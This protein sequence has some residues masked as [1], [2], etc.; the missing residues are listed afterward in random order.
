MNINIVYR[1]EPHEAKRPV[2]AVL[3]PVPQPGDRGGYC[4]NVM[5]QND[6]PIM[7]PDLCAM[8]VRN[9]T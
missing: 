5:L 9:G 1:E 7:P 4:G 2:T 6:I 3:R 8:C